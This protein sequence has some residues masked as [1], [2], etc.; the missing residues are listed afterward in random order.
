MLNAKEKNLIGIRKTKGGGAQN[1]MVK[2]TLIR[3]WHNKTINRE[4]FQHNKF[5]LSHTTD[6]SRIEETKREQRSE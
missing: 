2:Q 6:K 4:S 1:L 5:I 3:K